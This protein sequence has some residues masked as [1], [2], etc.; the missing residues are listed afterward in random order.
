MEKVNLFRGLNINPIPLDF[1]QSM[2]TLE[3]LHALLELYNNLIEQ[4]NENNDKIN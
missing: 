4:I 3:F 1:S 2:T